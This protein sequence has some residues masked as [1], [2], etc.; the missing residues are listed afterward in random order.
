MNLD[1]TAA[2]AIVL[3][4]AGWDVAAVSV[5]ATITAQS[6]G[7]IAIQIHNGNPESRS[8]TIRAAKR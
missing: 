1:F 8:V 3:L 7:H 6:D 2:R 5:P 4:P